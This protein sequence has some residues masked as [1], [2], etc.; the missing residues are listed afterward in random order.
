MKPSLF[1]LLAFLL[2]ACQ[3]AERT[4]RIGVS[5]CSDDEWRTK[6]NHEIMRE[7]ALHPDIDVDIVS[8]DDDN[9]KQIR[10]IQHFI[11][12]RVDLIIAAPNEAEKMTPVIEQAYRKGIK[13][14][15]FDRKTT[16]DLYTAYVGADNTAIGHE[17]GAHLAALIARKPGA[18]VV[19]IQG[20]PGASATTE[21]HNGFRQAMAEATCDI[22]ALTGNW[23]RDDAQ[24]AMRQYLARGGKRPDYIFAHNDR[25]AL[26]A[27]Q[28]LAGTDS[29][30]P[31][32]IGIDGVSGIETG[33]TTML[34]GLDMVSNR[35]IDITFLYPTGGDKIIRI[36][37][38]IL[39]GKP[40]ERE[41]VLET[42]L[43]DSTNAR[44]MLMQARGLRDLDQQI[45]QQTT[46]LDDFAKRND[47]N[48]SLLYSFII[49]LVLAI[50]ILAITIRNYWAKQQLNQQL[51]EDKLQQ[52]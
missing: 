43:I 22:V 15:L 11:D 35:L 41:T 27:R 52:A 26:G 50:A 34:H 21:R 4:F 10:D 25:M 1:L 20:L 5:Q 51:I 7:A 29:Q 40:Y 33:D 46:R 38:D 24:Q 2:A 16:S 14:L 23:N 42:A 30:L 8:A 6:M 32:I 3:P 9:D 18:T 13:V 39:H 31:T 45:S 19:E 28:A 47:L 17:A 49:I 36:A 12:Q 48:R 44:V 37:S